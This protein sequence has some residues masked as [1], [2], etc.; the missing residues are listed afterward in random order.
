MT[1]VS[2]ATLFFSDARYRKRLSLIENEALW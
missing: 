2:S 1:E